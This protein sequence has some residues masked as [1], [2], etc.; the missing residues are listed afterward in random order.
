MNFA[1]TLNDMDHSLP[2]FQSWN[3][4]IMI[5]LSQLR[6]FPDSSKTLTLQRLL[7]WIKFLWLFIKNIKTLNQNTLKYWQICLTPYGRRNVS[8]V[9]GRYQLYALF[10]RKQVCTHPNCNITPPIYINI[11]SKLLEFII[12]KEGGDHLNKNNFLSEK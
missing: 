10:S 6:N 4:N 5:S 3:T 2:D 11:I 7:I 1:F 8:W 9:Y 12:N